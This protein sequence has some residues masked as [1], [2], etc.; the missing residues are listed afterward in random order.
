[1]CE[2]GEPDE[3]ADVWNVRNVKARKE[4]RCD[5]C[6]AII[7]PGEKYVRYASLYD[8]SWSVEAGCLLCDAASDEF[9]E[10]HGGVS[11]FPSGFRDALQNCIDEEDPEDAKWTPMLE[12]M[13]SRAAPELKHGT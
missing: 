3:Y 13:T 1:M 9:G 2:I 11:M 7:K 8:G 12:A 4:R 5:A 6:R 10:A